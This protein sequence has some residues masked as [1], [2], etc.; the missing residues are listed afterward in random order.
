[1]GEIEL[2]E[3]RKEVERFLVE[4]IKAHPKATY[5]ALG[6]SNAMNMGAVDR[7]LISEKILHKASVGHEVKGKNS[8]GTPILR[9]LTKENNENTDHDCQTNSHDCKYA[10]LITLDDDEDESIRES[11]VKDSEHEL[12][13]KAAQFM[14]DIENIAAETQVSV[15]YISDNTEEGSQLL[16]GFYGMGAILRYP[17]M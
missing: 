6:I 16:H 3:E 9:C 8:D 4:L 13:S 12:G 2:D 1:M 7:L 17:M 14:E 10:Y 11:L 5:G 15:V